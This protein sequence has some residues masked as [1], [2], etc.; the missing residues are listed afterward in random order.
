VFGHP[1]KSLGTQ[2]RIKGMTCKQLPRLAL[3]IG[4]WLSAAGAVADSFSRAWITVEGSGRISDAIKTAWQDSLLYPEL[5]AEATS[6]RLG[7][8]SAQDLEALMQKYPDSVAIANLR[9]RKLFRLGR[10]NWHEDFLFLYR[11]T[12]NVKLNCFKLEARLKLDRDTTADRREALRIWTHGRSRPKE[13]DPLF[14]MMEE[15]DWITDEVRLQRID[16]ALAKGQLRLARWLAKK[17]DRSATGHIDS[18][19]QARSNPARFL[20]R[21][22]DQYPE[23]VDMAASR[24]ARRNPDQILELIR[25]R[26]VP[27]S[28]REAAIVGAAR[29]MAINRDP[30]AAPLLR[31]DLPEHPV[32]DHWRVRYFIHFQQ[33]ND[34]LKSIAQ[35]PPA[36]RGEIEWTYW[37]SRA[38]AMTG[39]ADL[40]FEGF[41]TVAESNSWY[42]FLAADYLG[43]PYDLRPKST[44]PSEAMIAR[45]DQRTDV[46]VA[47]LLFQAGLNVMARRQWDFTLGRLSEDQQKAAAILANRWNWYSRSA[48]TAHQSGLTDDYELRYPLAY[49]KPLR[50]AA[51]R[52]GVSLTLL[53][54][55]MR[56]ESL[57][58][59]DVRS[60]AG[61]LGLMQIMPRT[62]R[63]TARQLNLRWRGN[64]SLINPSTNIRIGSFYLAEQLKRFGH[65]A[66]A[67]AAYNAG[68]HRVNQWMPETAMPLDAWVASIPF[69]ET[70]N[71]VQRVLGAQVIYEWRY[72]GA[73]TRLDMLADSQIRRKD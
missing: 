46:T 4:L 10:A 64:R 63:Q 11:Q 70:R 27:D 18:W 53:S 41:R 30:A 28:A 62:G 58:M 22:A 2:A 60:P 29:T 34:V 72:T 56:S 73:I 54:G 44:R 35:M 36:T 33:W 31:M 12:D 5:I 9:W 38:L 50:T 40:A 66:M 69:R 19:A 13:C 68:P 26:K 17:L 59:F 3:A 39:S 14:A 43:L 8:I 45:V 15:R 51:D 37:S 6:Q 67:A 25:D 20:T 1:V 21:Q 61:A 57:F 71:Y 65:P 7:Q 49:E 16:E 48:V 52:E 32:L 55:L 42:G 47:K 23:W 24:L